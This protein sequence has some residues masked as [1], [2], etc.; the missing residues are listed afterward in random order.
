MK[1]CAAG[2]GPVHPSGRCHDAAWQFERAGHAA[3]LSP[4]HDCRRLTRP[5]QTA[6]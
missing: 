4:T 1:K 3:G 5:W 6:G 2:T